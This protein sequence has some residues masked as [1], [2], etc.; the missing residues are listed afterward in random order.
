MHLEPHNPL[1]LP[2]FNPFLMST[3]DLSVSSSGAKSSKAAA[4][5]LR[6]D[7]AE[8]QEL[9]VHSIKGFSPIIFDDPVECKDGLKVTGLTQTDDLEITG[10][11]LQSTAGSVSQYMDIRVNDQFYRIALLATS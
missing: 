3:A 1:F 4:S 5:L 2:P 9:K 6:V 11:T 7:K 8:I 10:A